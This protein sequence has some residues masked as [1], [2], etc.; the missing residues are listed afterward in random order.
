MSAKG[1]ASFFIGSPA[2]FFAP[3]KCGYFG[4]G[5]YIMDSV[6]RFLEQQIDCPLPAFA[7]R[8]GI[9]HRQGIGLTGQCL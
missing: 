8:L 7:D 9:V 6:K 2:F 5:W 4:P 1:M 3:R